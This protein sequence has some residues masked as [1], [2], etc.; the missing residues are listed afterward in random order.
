MV[1]SKI[2]YCLLKIDFYRAA[3]MQGGLSYGKGVCPSVRHT[4]EL[5]QNERK[6]R[7][8]SYT[9]WKEN[10]CS[11]S[12]TYRVNINSIPYDFC[13]YFSNVWRFLHEILQNC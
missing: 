9:I 13:W 7:R 1:F 5:W 10:S 8:D 12:D 6:F 11:F 3:Y 2:D 4:R